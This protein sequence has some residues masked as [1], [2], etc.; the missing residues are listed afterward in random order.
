VLHLDRGYDSPA[1]RDRLRV[2]GIDPFEIQRRGAKVPGV[3]RQPLRL[4]RR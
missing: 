3:K 2:A 4:G 1:V